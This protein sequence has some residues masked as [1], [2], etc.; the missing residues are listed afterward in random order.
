MV[1]AAFRPL[2]LQSEGCHS[3]IRMS[4]WMLYYLVLAWTCCIGLDML[5]WLRHTPLAWTSR[6]M[7][8]LNLHAELLGIQ[9]QS[10]D[11]PS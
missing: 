6:P 1:H 10:D 4:R 7:H 8:A 3:A 11:L 2:G 9:H 5:H